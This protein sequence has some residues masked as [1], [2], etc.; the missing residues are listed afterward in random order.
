MRRL[1]A[2]WLGRLH[3]ERTQPNLLGS[4]PHRLSPLSDQHG[5]MPSVDPGLGINVT[6]YTDTTYTD[7]TYTDTT[8]TPTPRTPTPLESQA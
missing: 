1:G 5:Y 8:G 7:T 2:G 3:H 4:S 6:T